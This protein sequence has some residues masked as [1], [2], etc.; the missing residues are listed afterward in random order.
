MN[1]LPNE[2]RFPNATMEICLQKIEDLYKKKKN[3]EMDNDEL[4]EYMGLSIKSGYANRLIAAMKYYEFINRKG[5]KWIIS[6]I[7]KKYIK[8]KTITE[9]EFQYC[10]CS[11]PIYKLILDDYTF[12]ELIKN[13]FNIKEYLIQRHKFS[14]KQI[15]DFSKIHDQN[16]KFVFH[17]ELVRKMKN[18][19]EDKIDTNENNSIKNEIG[20][21]VL[22]VGNGKNIQFIYPE[23][24]SN[25]Q[26]DTIMNYSIEYIKRIISSKYGTNNEGGK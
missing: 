12:N 24:L 19:I 26:L 8:T 14:S 16:I 4:Y 25:E 15:E 23:D 2:S 7:A 9:K 1:K 11:I 17:Y 10:I 21:I 6:D 20:H 5:A 22:P 13:E 18:N 3:I